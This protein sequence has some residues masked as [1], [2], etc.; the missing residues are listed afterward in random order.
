MDPSENSTSVSHNAYFINWPPLFCRVANFKSHST[1]NSKS[2]NH[3]T[4]VM[5]LVNVFLIKPYCA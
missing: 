4:E 3:V 5:K 2:I 1:K